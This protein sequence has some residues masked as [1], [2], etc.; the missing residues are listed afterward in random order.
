[1]FY[2]CLGKENAANQL[3]VRLSDFFGIDD[4]SIELDDIEQNQ[5]AEAFQSRGL[6]FLGGITSGF[7]G[8][9]IW[10]TME[11]KTYQVE[12][13]NGI[14]PYTI[15]LLAGFIFRSWMDYLTLGEIGTGGWTDQKGIIHCVKS[16]Y[17]LES[18][19][20]KISLLKHE[21][22]HANDLINNPN[23]TS[24]EL[25]YRAKLVELIYSNKRNLLECFIREA[26]STD[27]HNGHA[28]ASSRILDDI[29]KKLNISLA[30]IEKISI[31]QIQTVAMTLYKE[32]QM[33]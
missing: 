26:D 20:F 33:P 21:A 31:D 30:E 28:F 27:Q 15:K 19:D 11:T 22:Q 1:M 8:P 32:I 9:Y 18:E 5:I 23:M 7:Y 25:E 4:E 2:L 6:Y 17:D 29:I 24:E 3:R 16:S 14:Q 12:L 13:P 10:R